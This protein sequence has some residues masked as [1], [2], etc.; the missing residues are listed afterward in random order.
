MTRHNVASTVSATIVVLAV[1]G[2]VANL[3]KLGAVWTHGP[4]VEVVL[5]IV[6]IPIAPLGVVM[7]YL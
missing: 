7:G 3:V 1:G 6:G 5:R 4:T 2:W